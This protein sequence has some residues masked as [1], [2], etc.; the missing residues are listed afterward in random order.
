V[1]VD[2]VGTLLPTALDLVRRGGKVL[3]FGMNQQATPPVPQNT[4][5]RYEIS[6]LGTYIAKYTFPPAIRVLE[7]GAINA[8]ALITHR[9][10]IANIQ[11]GLDAMRYG[12]AVKVIV[13]PE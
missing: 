6:V 9:V 8:D 3:L 11:E 1:V 12:E 7:S 10:N 4:I 2:A 5:T 13:S